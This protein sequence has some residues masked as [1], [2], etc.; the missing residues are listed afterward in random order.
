MTKLRY[1]ITL[2]FVFFTISVS[3]QEVQGIVYDAESN[4]VI[5]YVNVV[6]DNT[7]RG[8]VSGPN[9]TFSLSIQGLDLNEIKLS[10]SSIGY[11]TH[12]QSIRLESESTEAIE[13]YLKASEITLDEVVVTPLA[14]EEYI[15]RAIDQVSEN[16]PDSAFVCKGYFNEYLK[17]NKVYLKFSEGLMEMW[18]PPYGDTTATKV[19]I[20]N[21]R[22]KRDLGQLTFMRKKLDKMY[23]K[24]VKKEKEKAL[25]GGE[26]WDNEEHQ[27]IDQELLES[28]LGG[29]N[30]VTFIDP[31]YNMDEYLQEKHFKDFNYEISRFTEYQGQKVMVISFKS[32]RKIDHIKGHGEIYLDI[33]KDVIVAVKAKGKFYVPT[34]AKPV[35]FVMGVK[36]KSAVFQKEVHYRNI[37]GNF[38][39]SDFETYIELDLINLKMFSKNVPA[40]FEIEQHYFVSNIEKKAKPPF[41]KSQWMDIEKSMESQAV[42]PYNEEMWEEY[43]SLRPW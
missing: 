34:L 41:P 43:Q 15:K 13:V 28:S 38:Y 24:E 16:Y 12:Q 5:P 30:V 33:D 10:F 14:P 29:P 36:V 26:E 19:R 9:G 6:I 1:S 40:K 20:L 35:L 3:A 32:K 4:E 39:L 8:T 18:H 27:S 11:Q 31:I 42:F 7:S 23:D 25:K 21:A 22:A 37:N 2:L 17:E